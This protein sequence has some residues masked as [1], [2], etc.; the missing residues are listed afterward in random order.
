[1]N[2]IWK[3]SESE[4]EIN[5]TRKVSHSIIILFFFRFKS[6]HLY[7]KCCQQRY[8]RLEF[9]MTNNYLMKLIIIV[10]GNSEKKYRFHKTECTH[11]K[12]VCC[13]DII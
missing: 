12:L 10:Y 5:D 11:K 8:L 6:V 2:M 7:H 4:T 3:I 9:R 13:D 1:M